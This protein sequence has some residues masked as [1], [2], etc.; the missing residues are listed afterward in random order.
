MTAN[1]NLKQ[2]NYIS[3][4]CL[5]LNVAINFSLIPILGAFG[6]AIATACTQLSAGV[7]QMIF[8]S[9]TFNY[10][11]NIRLVT[12]FAVFSVFFVLLN[13]ML[14][15]FI[16]PAYM[17]AFIALPSGVALLLISRIVRVEQITRLIRSR[18]E[19]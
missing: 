2:L 17:R 15:Q 5:V 18:S 14:E 12:S 3:F 7:F 13:L 6:A 19:V 1:G 10:G 16:E 4:G 8:V 11:F 9:R